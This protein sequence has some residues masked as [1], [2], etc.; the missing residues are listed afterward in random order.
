MLWPNWH[1]GIYVY[2]DGMAM[3]AWMSL[4]YTYVDS[5]STISRLTLTREDGGE[6]NLQP[7]TFI[8]P[9]VEHFSDV[10]FLFSFGFSNGKNLF[11]LQIT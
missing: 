8:S 1:W 5:R 11:P 6:I 4:R 2:V 9:L 3:A 10:F 7:S